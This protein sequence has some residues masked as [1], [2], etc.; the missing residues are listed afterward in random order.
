MIRKSIAVAAASALLLVSGTASAQH[1]GWCIG[2]GNKHNAGCA[3]AGGVQAGGT[4]V[5]PPTATP[6]QPTVGGPDLPG[7]PPT[8]VVPPLAPQATPTLVP[9][10]V[11]AQAPVAVP[12]RVPPLAPQATPTLVPQAVPPQ[13]PVAV[14]SRVPPLAPQATPTLVPQAVPAQAPV[15]VPPRVPPLAP[16]ATP[17]LVPQAVP[18]QAPVAVPPRVPP[19]APQGTPT[20]VPQAVP[21]KAPVATPPL[22]PSL[23]NATSS[24]S[25]PAQALVLLPASQTTAVVIRRPVSTGQT[26]VRGVDPQSQGVSLV[27]AATHE[28]WTVGIVTEQPGRQ[29]GH[30]APSYLT[31]DGHLVQCLAGGFGWRYVVSHDGSVRLA[32]RL[33]VL[34]TTDVIVRDLPANHLVSPECVVAVRRRFP[35]D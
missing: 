4:T 30:S 8:I 24:G 6:T 32:G 2:V 12:P 10:A 13:A 15:A 33:P 27:E 20:I 7:T 28:P 3:P 16:Q 29:R 17:T 1:L 18:A 21:P 31:A 11:A 34:R 19:L 5:T 26:P 25:S 9:Q 14:P 35:A 23:V 22:S